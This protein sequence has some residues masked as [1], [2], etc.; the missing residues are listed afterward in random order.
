MHTPMFILVLFTIV[1]IGI[2]GWKDVAYIYIYTQ[3]NSTQSSDNEILTRAVTLMDIK[4]IMLSE[5]RQMEKNKY[6]MISFICG[7]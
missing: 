6:C 4:D 1:R 2:K 7:I 3:W 5:T